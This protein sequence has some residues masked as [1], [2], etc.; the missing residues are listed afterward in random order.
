MAIVRQHHKDTGTTYVLTNE[1]Y[2]DPEAKKTRSRRKIIGKIDPETGEII[3]TGR[4]PEEKEVTALTAKVRE[5][6]IQNTELQTR[7]NLLERENMKLRAKEEDVGRLRT[8]NRRM[9][10]IIKGARN[11]AF[12]I[13]R[14]FE[15]DND[16][17][18]EVLHVESGGIQEQREGG[19]ERA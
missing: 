3:P 4:R 12:E 6:E 14:L 9:K 5:L 16:R 13:L 7:V 8:D 11:S 17:E 18:S 19:V 2:W 15:T 10:N 1:R